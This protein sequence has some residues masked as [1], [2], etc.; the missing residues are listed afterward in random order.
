MHFLRQKEIYLKYVKRG[1]HVIDVGANCGHI[2][3]LLSNIV[4]KTGK[5]Y[6][7]EAVK[8]TFEK[9]QANIK[10]YRLYNNITL[11]NYAVNDS[12]ESI[13]I[14][15]PGDDYGQASMKKHQTGSWAV[16]Q[17]I[18]VFSC[19]SITLDKQIGLFGKVDFI[20]MDI[21]GAELLALKGSVEILKKFKPVLYIEVFKHW[22]MEFGYH[23]IDIYNFLRNMG[24]KKFIIENPEGMFDLNDPVKQLDSDYSADLICVY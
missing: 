22:T 1:N 2:C 7:Y 8:P 16:S 24:Y 10:D 21:E 17:Q 23:P 18:T 15:V 6:A 5:V 9:L 14:T 13:T 12:C 11:F 20:K 3:L 4:G 19:D